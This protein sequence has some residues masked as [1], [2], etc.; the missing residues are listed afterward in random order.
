MKSTWRVV[1]GLLA[2]VLV[3]LGLVWAVPQEVLPARPAGRAAQGSG[4]ASSVADLSAIEGP[5]VSLP[6]EPHLSRP[7]GELPTSAGGAYLDR[8]FNPRH[9]PNLLDSDMGARGTWDRVDVPRDPLIDNAVNRETQSPPVEL[10]F[11]ATGNPVAC[12]G[13]TP[14]DVVGDVG[15]NH[16]VHMVNVK[17]AV[18]DKSGALL[19]GPTDFNQ[20]FADTGGTCET[21][22]D[23][24]PV[25]LYDPLADRW[26]LAQFVCAGQ[27]KICAAVSE[28]GDPTGAYYTYEFD[29]PDG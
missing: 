7:V 11:D 16:Y 26:L 10:A 13:C 22:N 2:L 18:Y 9:N 19:T 8:E 21:T 20:L 1:S 29:L 25:P 17:F 12:D 27:G 23:G 14:P 28:T 4:G 5:Y 6:V 15:P 3:G 24:D